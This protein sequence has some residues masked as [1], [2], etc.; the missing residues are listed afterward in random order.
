MDTDGW[1]GA[2][3]SLLFLALLM[4]FWI[5][6]ASVNNASRGRIKRQ[7]DS[8]SKKA[9]VIDK[10]LDDTESLFSTLIVAKSLAVVGLFVAT[11][12]FVADA[13][14]GLRVTPV[15]VTVAVLIVIIAL[16]QI[17]CREIALR[18]SEKI[19]VGLSGVLSVTATTLA[20]ISGLVS[21]LARAIAGIFRGKPDEDTDE[22]ESDEMRLLVDENQEEVDLE[23]DEKDMI[24]AVVEL[25]ETLARE[26]MIPRIDV[27]AAAKESSIRQI[28]EIIVSTGYSRIPIYEDTIDNIVGLVYA[29]D[30][31]PIL[32]QG[33]IE[34][35]I[36]EIA[37]TPHFIPE[38]KKVDDLL[39]EFQQ[40]KVH[41]AIVVD[42]YGGTAGLVTI[43]D[44]L[45]EIV[46]EIEDEYDAEESKVERVSDSEAVMNAK[47]SIDEVKDIFG[48]DIEGEDYDTVGGFVFSRLGRI[49]VVADVIE[50]DGIKIEVLTTVGRRVKEVKISKISNV[51]TKDNGSDK[52]E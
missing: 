34:E 18:R 47:V 22:D 31:L 9:R 21:F 40:S 49:P 32:E 36:T 39:H 1:L 12:V 33:K 25:D 4:L 5:A 3:L 44:L 11:S 41:V 29:K 48:V 14:N 24:R 43:E 50:I 6:E 38:S 10:L 27:V 17:V 51:K 23:Q 35:P 20:P 2:V 28:I 37:R 13:Y 30:L 42:E 19:V 16:L 7:A 8:G 52:Q 26:I 45:E 46:G 15:I